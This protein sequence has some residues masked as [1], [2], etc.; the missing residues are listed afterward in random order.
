MPIGENIKRLRIMHGLSQKELAQIA[1]V[2]DKAVSTWE[3]GTKEPR[4]GAVQKIADYFGLKKSNLIEDN[5]LEINITPVQSP[6]PASGD[7]PTV[8]PTGQKIDART[9][10]QLE[11]V[12]DDDNLTYN[13]VVLNGE[14]KEKVKKALELIFW[15]VKEKNKRKKD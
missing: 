15:D 9:R 7:L 11:A 12:L 2:S 3:N 6:A 13:G 4:M 1:G 5:G 14:D 10:R 8:S